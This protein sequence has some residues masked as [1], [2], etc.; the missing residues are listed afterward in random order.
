MTID[1]KTIER[2]KGRLLEEKALLEK[3]LGSVG[4]RDAS[5]PGGW[6]A[7]SGNLE[8]DPADDAEVANKIEELGDNDGIVDK[9]EGQLRDVKDALIRIDKG[10]Y[11]VCEVSNEPIEISR[12]EASPS[13][14]TCIKHAR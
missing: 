7:T 12:L 3:E 8:I 6:D 1:Q 11:G 4:K 13:A 9:L 2:F 10:I 5:N 14:R